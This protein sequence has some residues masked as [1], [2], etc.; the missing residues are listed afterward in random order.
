M[1]KT[2]PAIIISTVLL[3][4]GCSLAPATPPTDEPEVQEVAVNTAPEEDP[5]SD[6]SGDDTP[7]EV[8]EPEI[9]EEPEEPELPATVTILGTETDIHEQSLD[10][11]AMTPEDV[12]AVSEAIAQMPELGWINLMNE[13]GISELSVTDVKALKESAPEVNFIYDFDLFGKRVSTMDTEITYAWV[14][15]GNEGEEEI[16][17]ALSIFNDCQYFLLDDCGID[18]EVMDSIR[19]D[20]PDTKVVWR[21]HVGT[22]SALTDDQVIRMTHGINDSMTEALKYCHDVVYM[23]LGHDAGITDISFIQYMPLL[24]CIIL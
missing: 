23:D 15:I 8:Q 19:N 10:L 5:V 7:T 9:P 4:G 2:I 3:A 12:P 16:R 17:N 6:V 13:E 1:K 20:F 24:E 18:N 22:R 21:I 14:P 11:A